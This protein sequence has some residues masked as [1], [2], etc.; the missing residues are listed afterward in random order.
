MQ[1]T[2]VILTHVTFDDSPYFRFIHEHAK[3][4]VKQGYKAVVLAAI[5]WLPILSCFQK[6][7]KYFIAKIK[8]K[9]KVQIIDGVEVRYIK[10]L[11]FSNLLYNSPI[12]LN[13]ISYYLRIKSIFKKINRENDVILID[14]HMFKVEGY[15]AYKL[16]KRYP[17][18]KTTITLHGTSFFRN[19]S[20]KNGKRSIRKIFSVV[21]KAVCVSNKIKRMIE[22]IGVKNTEIIYN[23]I[24]QHEFSKI[25][26]QQYKNQITIVGALY[27]RKKIDLT[28]RVFANLIKRYPDL[29][30]NI[31]G[32]GPERER[33]DEIV[34]TLKLEDSVS[35]KGQITNQEVLDLMN[36]SYI[37][38]LPSVAEGFGIVYAEAM[39]AGCITIGTKNEGIDGFII[40]GKNGFLVNPEEKEI[41]KLIEEIYENKYDIEGIRKNA[42]KAV[43]NLTWEQNAKNYLKLLKE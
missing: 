26:K 10:T 3:E 34:K 9:N 19:A 37:F 31:V 28:I 17:N 29:K 40:N 21:D 16:K 25:D 32:A 43:E 30:L 11:S 2:I 41:T 38:I 6:Y 4:L 27:P 13:G 24:N 22:N 8:N 1:K 7:K 33:L 20:T 5:N 42:Y 14:A 23:G 35:F 18:I 12:N 36:K 15:A 39:K